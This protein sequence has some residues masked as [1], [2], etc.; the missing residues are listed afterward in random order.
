MIKVCIIGA[1]QISE[2]Y[3]K[4]LKSFKIIKVEGIVSRTIKSCK[5]KSKK[6]SIPYYGNSIETVMNIVKPNIVIICVTP[7]E[8]KKVCMKILKYQCHVLIEKPVGLNLKENKYILNI[9]NKYEGK[10]FVAL[11]RRYFS[12][13]IKLM[14]K[15]NK[16]NSKRVVNIFDQ[17]NTIA[18]KKNGHSKKVIKNWMFANSIHLIDL[19]SILCRG[20]IKKISKEKKQLNNNEHY[21]IAN[22]EFS[23][24]DLGVYHAYWNRPAPW[25]ITVSCD[26][27]FF[28]M[29]PIENLYEMDIKRKIINYKLTQVDK[30]YKPGFYMMIRDLINMY[31]KNKN[32]LV[33]VKKNL[34]TMKLI[35]KLYT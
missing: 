35:D 13:T 5:E 11:N 30:K 19:F 20:K 15:L 14:S 6:F 34:E 28:Y 10:I 27:S 16:N 2:Q 8:T 12:S 7:S 29:S 1:G 25:K 33:S 22:I 4:V 9:A 32:N 3:I 21:M 24:G 17:E 23:S 18:A 31:K 26:K